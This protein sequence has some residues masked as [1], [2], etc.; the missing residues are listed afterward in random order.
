MSPPLLGW[1]LA[2]KSIPQPAK[3]QNGSGSV[4]VILTWSV[5][6]LASKNRA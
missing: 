2:G 4:L 3:M 5:S 1:K 6:H